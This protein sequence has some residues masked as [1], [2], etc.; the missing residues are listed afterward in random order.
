MKLQ[1]FLNY[2]KSNKGNDTEYVPTRWE[3]DYCQIE[4]IPQENLLFVKQQINEAS[5][6]AE[7][8]KTEFGYTDV[9]I[10]KKNPT[11]TRSKEIRADYLRSTLILFQLPELTNIRY[12]GGEIIS[13]RG[14]KTQ[15]FGFLNFTLFFDI[16]G[17]FVKNIWIILG[18]IIATGKFDLILSALYYL[19]EE[20]DLI[21]VD[22][23]SDEIVD[24]K[25]KN[26]I[27]EY[28]MGW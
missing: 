20:T 4:L 5:F 7:E 24:I 3:D 17:E 9:F 1:Q 14:A 27:K 26:Q 6:F 10:R 12:E 21:L 15:A 11:P 19:G 18:S 13:H 2:F 25:N 22:W 23:N 8:H 28:L 16:E